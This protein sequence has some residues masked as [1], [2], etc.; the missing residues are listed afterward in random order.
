MALPQIHATTELFHE[1][2]SEYVAELQLHMTLH[3]RNLVPSFPEERQTKTQ[4]LD[5]RVQ[6][7]QESQ[8]NIE[9][10]VSRQE[11]LSCRL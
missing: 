5:S 9:K 3:A 4:P 2:I 8:A 10:L 6:L 7:L 1:D 11:I